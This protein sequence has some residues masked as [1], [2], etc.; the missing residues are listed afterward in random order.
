LEGEALA[1]EALVLRLAISD[2]Q[3]WI[4]VGANVTAL[5]PFL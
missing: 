5:G 1:L 4:K 2:G 3:G